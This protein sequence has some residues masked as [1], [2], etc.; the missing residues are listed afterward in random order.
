MA[1]STPSRISSFR[2]YRWSVIEVLLLHLQASIADA[3]SYG[4]TRRAIAERTTA[5]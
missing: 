4:C 1:S 3:A 2:A 5:V